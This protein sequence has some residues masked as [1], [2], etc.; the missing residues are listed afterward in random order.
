[1]VWYIFGLK[2]PCL[3]RVCMGW[4]LNGAGLGGKGGDCKSGIG[5]AIGTA[6][7]GN[8]VLELEIGSTEGGGVKV[9]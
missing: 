7:V 9:I 8:G 1:M 3:E 6:E 2:M 4:V 5:G